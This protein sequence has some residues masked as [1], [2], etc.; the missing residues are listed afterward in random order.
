MYNGRVF[1]ESDSTVRAH[2]DDKMITA[3]IVLPDETYHIEV[4][5]R[6]QI[7]SA[8]FSLLPNFS[9]LNNATCFHSHR[10][11]MYRI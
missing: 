2:I 3:N 1:G 11:D 7:K 9:V 6:T 5:I 10:G 4:Y 8:C